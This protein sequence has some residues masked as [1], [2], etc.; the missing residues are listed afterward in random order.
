MKK[1]MSE[2]KLDYFMVLDLPI[3]GKIG[4]I[5]G[6]G[7]HYFT[8]MSKQ[9][10]GNFLKMLLLELLVVNDEFVTEEFIDAMSLN[11]LIY[12]MS[13]IGIMTEDNYKNGF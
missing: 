6:K 5:D 13:V 4:L 12:L 7:I 3:Y 11:D 10:D 1:I 2:K 8:A 9:T